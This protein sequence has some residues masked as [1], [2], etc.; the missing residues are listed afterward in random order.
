MIKLKNTTDK[1]ELYIPKMVVDT[2][3]YSAYE[4]KEITITENGVYE[5]FPS[6]GKKGISS[7]VITVNIGENSNF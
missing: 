1:Q 2:E 6:N 5:I 4:A 3:V 7:I